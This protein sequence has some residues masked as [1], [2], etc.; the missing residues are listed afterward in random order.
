MPYLMKVYVVGRDKPV[1][2]S[3]R[4]DDDVK[5]AVRAIDESLSNNQFVSFGMMGEE[6][7]IVG[8]R[9]VTHIEITA[10]QKE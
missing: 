6:E 1:Y 9:N 2:E 3:E 4:P 10:L 5:K 7:V 8:S